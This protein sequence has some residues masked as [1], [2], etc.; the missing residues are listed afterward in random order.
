VIK[1]ITFATRARGVTPEGFAVTWYEEVRAASAAPPDARPARVAVCTAMTEL[2]EGAP[3]HDGMGFEWFPDVARLERFEAWLAAEDMT[4]DGAP[5]LVADELVLR[6]SD[7]LERRWRDGGERLKHMAL[8]LRAPG[9][10]REQFSERWTNHAGRIGPAGAPAL[11]IPDEAR[12]RAYVQ[13]H[14][15]ARPSGDWPYDAVN[16][17]YFDDLEGLRARIDW[18][19]ANFDPAGDDL[20]R[21]S[22]FVAAREDLLFSAG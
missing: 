20:V 14:P 2:S 11:V 3:R 6:G 13:N 16:E 4:R 8:A 9:L 22:W 19:R 7:W 10:T 15:R 1:R 17:V 12:G 21:E 18:F 5:V